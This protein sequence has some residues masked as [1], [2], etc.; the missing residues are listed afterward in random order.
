MAFVGSDSEAFK[1]DDLTTHTSTE[2]EGCE[3]ACAAFLCDI[4]DDDNVRSTTLPLVLYRDA[5]VEYLRA[6][7]SNLPRGYAALDAR[8]ALCRRGAARRD[9]SAHPSPTLHSRTWLVY[10]ITHSLALLEAPASELN[11]D[12]IRACCSTM[13]RTCPSLCFARSTATLTRP[14]GRL[15]PQS[16][17]RAATTSRAASEGA[18]ARCGVL[19]CGGAD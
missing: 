19:E 14:L 9:A 4:D 1:D 13:P 5:H 2:Q 7:L 3:D 16:F 17:F 18:P 11:G 10:W 8:C 15:T 6:G 12:I